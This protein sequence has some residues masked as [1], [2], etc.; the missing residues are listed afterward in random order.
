MTIKHLKKTL[1]VLA[2]GGTIFAAQ[3][4]AAGERYIPSDIGRLPIGTRL[5]W[6]VGAAKNVFTHIVRGR[7]KTGYRVDYFEG[8][9]SEGPRM[10]TNWF[11]ANGNF[12]QQKKFNGTI[13]RFTPH[14]CNRTIGRCEYVIKQVGRA[15][16]RVVS[17]VAVSGTAVRYVEHNASTGH[18]MIRGG[19]KVGANGLNTSGWS[20]SPNQKKLAI[21]LRSV[22]APK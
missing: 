11:D 20:R 12:L 9:T 16:L 22:S 7:D 15:D 14:R 19:F 4:A 5:V 21:R 3:M 10:G 1:Q 6:S 18:E 8:E 13:L 17:D 2:I